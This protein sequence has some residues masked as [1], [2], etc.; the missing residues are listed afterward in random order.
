MIPP[1]K[2]VAICF[3]KVDSRRIR[4]VAASAPAKATPISRK[5]EETAS[6]C[7]KKIMVKATIILAPEE[8]PS[9]KG[10]AIGL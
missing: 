2:R 1:T 10:P 5:E 9:T 4:S 8:M 3:T 6:Y 7:K